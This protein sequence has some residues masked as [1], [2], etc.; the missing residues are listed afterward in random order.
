MTTSVPEISDTRRQP[1]T[2]VDLQR[3]LTA[4]VHCGLCL[5]SC[6]TYLT[7]G[8]EMSSP[9]GRISMVRA[10]GAGEAE[11]GPQFVKHLDQ[12]LG[13]LGCQSACPSGVPYGLA[14]EE[15]RGVIERTVPRSPAE[16]LLRRLLTAIFPYPDRLGPLLRLLYPLQAS[17]LL[18]RLAGSGWL[19]RL[20]PGL[21]QMAALLPPIPSPATWQPPAER[22]AG[23]TWPRGR[24]GLMLGCAQRYLLPEVNRASARVLARAGYEVITPRRQGCCGALHLHLGDQTEARALARA[25][26]AAFDEADVALVVANAAGCGAAMK[27]YGHILE[28]DPDWRER[29]AAFSGRV[30][31][32]SELLADVDWNGDLRPVAATV[33][34]HDACH[35]AHAQG[36]RR[37][38][39]ALLGRIPGLR[40]VELPEADVCCGSAGVYNLLQPG[41]ADRIL[42]R[43]VVHLRGTGAEFVAAGNIGC[44]LQLG[45]GARQAGLAVQAVHPVELVDWA[46]RDGGSQGKD[47][48]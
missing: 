33:A 7:S 10:L 1:A 6:P 41:F 5:T 46:L 3:H 32:I 34:Y 48:G 37:E 30:K 35:L 14:L 27:D 45:L 2:A 36:I 26:I 18:P 20:S 8:I 43:K 39:R 25:M 47:G 13:C 12:C 16:R 11:I 31:D 9:R 24:V 40:L 19:R 4:C 22:T 23:L 15:A 42:A 21:A 28:D 29:A 38:P 44:L 17:G